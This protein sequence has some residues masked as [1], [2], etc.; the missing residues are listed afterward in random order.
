MEIGTE[1]CARVRLCPFC[2]AALEVR[3]GTKSARSRPHCL[4]ESMRVVLRSFQ[5]Q[6][7]VRV[8]GKANEPHNV[9]GVWGNLS[10]GF[11]FWSMDYKANR[12]VLR[13]F[14]KPRLLRAL[15]RLVGVVLLVICFLVRP[16]HG[17]YPVHESYGWHVFCVV[18]AW[19]FIQSFRLGLKAK[20]SGFVYRGYFVTKRIPYAMVAKFD[21]DGPDS[22]LVEMIIGSW[23]EAIG[24]PIIQN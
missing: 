12:R 2:R 14:R 19:F 7:T 16:E 3:G 10:S 21:W 17:S 1:A 20:R 6:R 15:F 5:R 24:W 8:R 23:Q 11:S 13:S 18:A 22:I 4:C 9:P